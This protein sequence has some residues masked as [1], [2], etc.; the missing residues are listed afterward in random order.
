MFLKKLKYWIVLKIPA[1]ENADRHRAE[2]KFQVVSHE[3]IFLKI[4]LKTAHFQLVGQF[5]RE[6]GEFKT[7]LRKYYDKGRKGLWN[8]KFPLS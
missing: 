3:F 6:V 2:G 7:Y 4:E 8:I 5:G 1:E